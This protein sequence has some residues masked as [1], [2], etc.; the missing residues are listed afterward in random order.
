MTPEQRSMTQCFST[1][2]EL[3]T[4]MENDSL[5]SGHSRVKI[6]ILLVVKVTRGSLNLFKSFLPPWSYSQNIT[7]NIQEHKPQSEHKIFKSR[8]GSVCF[9]RL[10]A[11]CLVN[12]NPA[13]ILLCTPHDWWEARFILAHECQDRVCGQRD[14]LFWQRELKVNQY[15]CNESLSACI[16]V[17]WGPTGYRYWK[18]SVYAN[19][20]W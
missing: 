2:F 6:C 13:F 5:E 18:V 14:G 8:I 15:I 4:Y 7:G 16:V 3:R 20:I 17:R 1:E 19:V 11:L 12:R 10:T 9:S